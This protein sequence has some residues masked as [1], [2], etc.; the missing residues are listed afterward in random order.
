MKDRI[1]LA[2]CWMAVVL[3]PACLVGLVVL[4]C[5]FVWSAATAM[6]LLQ[7]QGMEFQVLIMS[8]LTIF[9]LVFMEDWIRSGTMKYRQFYK[10]F[11][12]IRH[13]L[14]G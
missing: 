7:K 6:S 2:L 1:G 3:W 11:K 8:L 9:A 13:V 4:C 14:K 5:L 10:E 12:D